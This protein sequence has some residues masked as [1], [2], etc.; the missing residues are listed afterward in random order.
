ME[1]KKV[2]VLVVKKYHLLFLLPFLQNLQNTLKLLNVCILPYIG[3]AEIDCQAD[4]TLQNFGEI[5]GQIFSFGTDQLFFHIL[6]ICLYFLEHKIHIC[7]LI[8][9]LIFR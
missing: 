7:I 5:N 9:C 6:F 8:S 2:V 1:V 3:F 4:L